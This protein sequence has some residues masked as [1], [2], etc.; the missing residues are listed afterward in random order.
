MRE[1]VVGAA[2]L[3]A[4][5]GAEECLVLLFAD[6]CVSGGCLR[7]A[8]NIKIRVR[9]LVTRCSHNRARARRGDLADEVVLFD[10]V[11]A[12]CESVLPI[13][14]TLNRLIPS[15]SSRSTRS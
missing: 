7:P 4:H 3:L 1:P 10:A 5:H 8:I 2:D 9:P 13:M 11:M 12:V 6:A 15:F 14:P